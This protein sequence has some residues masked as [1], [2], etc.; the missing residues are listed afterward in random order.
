MLHDFFLVRDRHA[1]AEY[2]ERFHGMDRMFY[3]VNLE[4]H[5]HGVYTELSE[6]RVLHGRGKGM[7]YG[8]AE[9]AVESCVGVDLYIMRHN[10]YSL[11]APVDIFNTYIVISGDINFF[12]LFINNN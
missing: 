12:M 9:N 10:L 5:I 11:K 3:A 4:G 2:P 7:P 6:G 8:I 1:R